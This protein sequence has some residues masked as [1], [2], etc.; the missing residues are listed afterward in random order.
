RTYDRR[1][2]RFMPFAP[3]RA[4]DAAVVRRVK[5]IHGD[6]SHPDGLDTGDAF[7]KRLTTRVAPMKVFTIGFTQKSA[8]R[9]F[10]LLRQARVTRVIDV[11]LNNTGQ[12]AGFSK[13]DDLV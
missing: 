3:D 1:V 2:V 13:R 11:R 8:A 7:R 4:L 5:R 6:R 10:G 12:L 9:F